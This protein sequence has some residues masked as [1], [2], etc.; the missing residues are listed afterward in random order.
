MKTTENGFDGKF[1]FL[2]NFHIEPDGTHVEG[3]FQS[4]KT[5]DPDVRQ[6][7]IGLDPLGAKSLGNCIR[8]RPDWEKIKYSVM[9]RYVT[10]K[11]TDH[12]S[13][14]RKLLETDGIYLIEFNTWNDTVWG[15]VNGRGNN[16]LGRILMDVRSQL[17][18][19]IHAL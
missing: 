9:E 18:V 13:L 4:H 12:V 10:K 8:L 16:W 11:F 15:V 2:S 17:K 6:K 5:T 1:E 14:Q 3:E 19:C 7:F